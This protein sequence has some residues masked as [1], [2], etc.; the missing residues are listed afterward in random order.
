[1]KLG[2]SGLLYSDIQ[3]I[4]EISNSYVH[5]NDMFTSKFI[6]TTGVRQG[7]PKF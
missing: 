6:T 5:M 3:A 4:Y 7:D 2:V 1:M